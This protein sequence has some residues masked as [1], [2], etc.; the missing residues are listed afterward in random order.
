MG[1]GGGIDHDCDR[2]VGWSGDD[3]AA[4]IPDAELI[5]LDV[6]HLPQYREPGIVAETAL[7]TAARP[8]R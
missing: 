7:R 2:R 8:P 1:G 4:R 3:L 6:D 5:R